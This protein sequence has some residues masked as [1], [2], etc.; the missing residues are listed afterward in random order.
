MKKT[1]IIMLLF[2]PLTTM[3]Q[4]WEVPQGQGQ[5]QV[6]EKGAEGEEIN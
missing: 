4:V 6:V 2:L 1:A 3:A 5:N